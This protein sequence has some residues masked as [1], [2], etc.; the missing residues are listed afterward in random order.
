[1]SQRSVGLAGLSIRGADE[2]KLASE[3][4]TAATAAR[5]G[6]AG[7]TMIADGDRRP[8]QLTQRQ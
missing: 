6:G 4:R 7:I 8:G 3:E 5:T 2:L 1:M